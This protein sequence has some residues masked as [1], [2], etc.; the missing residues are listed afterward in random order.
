MTYA[1]ALGHHNCGHDQVIDTFL[2]SIDTTSV[3]AHQILV[4]HHDHHHHHL[5]HGDHQESHGHRHLAAQDQTSSSNTSSNV[6]KPL[7]VAF[8]LSKLVRDPGFACQQTGQLV[9]L[10]N[11]NY[12]CTANDVLTTDKLDFITTVLLPAAQEYFSSIL[13]VHPVDTLTVPG[14]KCGTPAWAC[15]TGSFPAQ[16]TSPGLSG[17]DFLLHVTARPVGTGVIAW[18]IP[19]NQDQFG[20]PISAQ[21]NFGPQQLNADP[22]LRITQIGT[23]LHELSHALGFSSS[24]FGSYRRPNNGLPWGAANVVQVTPGPN[25]TNIAR[26]TTPKV[27]QF[28]QTYFNCS[29]VAGGEL[30][31][32]NAQSYTS[33]WAKRLFLNEYMMATST[34]VPV[35]SMFTLAAFE[36]SGWY[37]VNYTRA[38]TLRYGRGGGCALA[39]GRCTDFPGSLC[40]DSQSRD[41]TPDYTSKG[42]CNLAAFSTP[43]PPAFQY[44]NSPFIGGRDAFANYCPR[45]VPLAGMDCRGIGSTPAARGSLLETIGLTS[46]CF[47]GALQSQTARASPTTASYCFQVQGCNATSL[48][49]AVGHTTVSCPFDQ[50]SSVVAISTAVDDEGNRYTGSLTCPRNPQDMCNVNLCSNMGVWTGSGCACSPGYTG[51]DCSH[52]VC[53]K[54]KDTGAV[55]SNN[56]VCV[57]GVCQCNST[58]GVGI[59]CSRRPSN[60]IMDAPSSTSTAGPLV[61]GFAFLALAMWV[62]CQ[63]QRRRRRANPATFPPAAALFSPK[64]RLLYF[65]DIDARAVDYGTDHATS[66]LSINI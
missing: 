27:K 20:R 40:Y 11:A 22:A 4:P 26:L 8:D 37:Q 39:T 60:E 25:A 65:Q 1:V 66:A 51:A 19:C 31:S 43:L 32:D 28:V 12:T 17:A 42:V 18:A 10:D 7:R 14:I 52:L 29:G 49:I 34:S 59:A 30:Q 56:G 57:N 48:Q 44:F 63:G 2:N 36:D 53:P 58:L 9:Q 47:R 50:G 16:Y 24:L 23:I 3:T 55:C 6:F 33:H 21:A 5:S 45:F 46:L 41:C 54:H 64:T 61:L 38:Q 35:Y 15:C 13:S 62:Y